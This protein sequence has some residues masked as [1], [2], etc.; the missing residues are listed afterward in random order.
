MIRQ[1]G[2][3]MLEPPYPI[4][5]S[6]LFSLLKHKWR[7]KTQDF[8]LVLGDK[9]NFEGF[10]PEWCISTTYHAWDTP[11]WSGTLDFWRSHEW[12]IQMH[13]L[14]QTQV[15]TRHTHKH[16]RFLTV[17]RMTNTKAH[18]GTDTGLHKTHPQI[19][20]HPPPPPPPP[21][22]HP[23]PPNLAESDQTDWWKHTGTSV[24]NNCV[25][26]F[27]Y[28]SRSEEGQWTIKQ[29]GKQ[30]GHHTWPAAWQ[31]QKLWKLWGSFSARTDRSITA[32]IAW[33]I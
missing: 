21:P 14:A 23:R 15:Y 4:T 33:I 16:P 18:I 13:T 1:T 2:E 5:I 28:P 8:V 24:S 11:F 22:A 20:S 12:Q 31:R 25:S 19:P 26:W 27:H 9:E 32:L 6:L 29:T 3:N 30:T 17:T 7:L 10:R